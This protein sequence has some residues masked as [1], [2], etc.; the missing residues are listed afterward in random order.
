LSP[1][2]YS[3]LLAD[4]VA[5]LR[6]LVR[7]AIESSGRFRVVGEA[8]D[9][10][11][12]ITEAVA[13]HPDLVLLDLS[14]PKMDGLEALPR[15]LEAVPTTRVVVLSGFNHVRM[16]PVAT[17][18]GASAYLEKGLEPAELVAS[19]LRLLEPDG[20]GTGSWSVGT[21]GEGGGGI[22]RLRD[23]SPS[24]SGS[25]TPAPAAAA[26]TPG[27]RALRPLRIVVL[28]APTPRARIEA[29]LRSS[30]TAACEP[31]GCTTVAEAARL[32]ETGSVD[33][34]VVQPEGLH[35]D[36]EDMLVGLLTAA[37]RQPVVAVLGAQ[38]PLDA[39]AMMRLGVEDCMPS[40]QLMP[41]ALGRSVLYA[42]QRRKAQEARLAA[43]D[44]EAELRRLR[45][46][47]QLKAEFFNA[48]AHELGTPL[49]PMRVQIHLLR[50]ATRALGPAE[51]RSL[52]VLDRNIARLAT[53]TKELLDVARLQSG[54]LS[55]EKG[56]VAL[57]DVVTEVVDSL[58]PVAETRGIHMEWSCAPD[59]VV[60]ADRKGIVQVLFNLVHN[61]VK[62][63][64]EGGTVTVDCEHSDEQCVVRVHDN[65][66]GL[67]QEQV[68]RLFRPFSQVLDDRQP[69]GLGSG[70][71]LFICRGIVE[72]HDGSI[73]CESPGPGQGSTFAF[74]IPRKQGPA[75]APASRDE[76]EPAAPHPSVP[77]GRTG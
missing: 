28:A 41:D 20:T 68:A 5:A 49:T 2:V 16:A 36:A 71:G 3:V 50:Q 76:P 24:G 4:D 52:E 43:R 74:S 23:P 42:I 55:A 73:W 27:N 33:A 13:L 59:E 15:I 18:L 25:G 75:A 35:A 51:L 46:L 64:P 77:K 9:G 48:A 10:G 53:L 17:R 8:S 30:A 65:G 21:G 26:W 44:Q 58:R 45:E 72:L 19:L 67:T 14:M 31:L 12:A 22:G 40:A 62:F 60:E 32:V 54:R 11:G 34:V 47:D 1:H 6:N 38:P 63:S 56:R 66:P 39:A 7:L 57:R 69:S 29:A 61:A 70:L 37:Q